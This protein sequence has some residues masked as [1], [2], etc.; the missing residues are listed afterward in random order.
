MA[1]YASTGARI[2]R[3]GEIA[4]D[5]PTISRF[6]ASGYVMSGSRNA[7]MNAMRLQKEN[8]VLTVEG[9]RQATLQSIQER[10]KREEDIV[11]GFREML[12]QR[13]MKGGAGSEPERKEEEDPGSIK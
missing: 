11:K 10:R 6:E 7:A 4:I 9:K 3:R 1:H 13:L 8:Q 5:A 2:P 12:N